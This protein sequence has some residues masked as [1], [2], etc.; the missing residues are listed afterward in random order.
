[1][2]VSQFRT[3]VKIQVKEVMDAGRRL[4]PETF[5][6]VA[7]RSY[8]ALPTRWADQV[9]IEFVKQLQNVDKTAIVDQTHGLSG[10]FLP[11]D[12]SSDHIP[13][14]EIDGWSFYRKHFTAFH[15]LGHFLQRTNV[16]CYARLFSIDNTVDSKRF[17]EAACNRFAAEVLLPDSLVQ[18]SLTPEGIIASD[19]CRLF[20]NAH[21]ASRQTVARRLAEYLPEGGSITYFD[22]QGQLV[23]RAS[24][25]G[26]VEYQIS[27]SAAETRMLEKLRQSN[28]KELIVD[29]IS[30]D[31]P[32]VTTGRVSAAKSH[33][34]DG[35]CT[36]IVMT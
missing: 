6:N 36:F 5:D 20:L 29:A 2:T 1:M 11:A 30:L 22:K 25:S 16:D 27:P 23:L 26:D 17:E 4:H 18:K 31:V 13:L 15:E 8:R 14:I 21:F 32:D 7:E 3:L 35:D 9:R 34:T 19:A 10:L 12:Q 33:S 24:Q 28:E